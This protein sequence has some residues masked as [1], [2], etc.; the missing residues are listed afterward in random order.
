MVFNGTVMRGQPAHG[1]LDGTTFLEVVRTASVYRLYSIGDRYPAMLRDDSKGAAIDAELY[2]VPD[3]VWP[4]IRNYEPAGLYRGA[5]ELDDGRV[6]E[7]MLGEPALVEYPGVVEITKF[8]GWC[9][10]LAARQ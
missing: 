9:A 8:G 4:R 6:L 3:A 10:Y 7:G 1:N 5:V 2:E